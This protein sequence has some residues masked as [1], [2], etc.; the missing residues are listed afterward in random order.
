MEAYALNI[1][2]LFTG[3]SDGRHPRNPVYVIPHFQRGYTWRK[4]KILVLINDLLEAIKAES[5]Q[6]FLGAIT[7][8]SEQPLKRTRFSVIDGQQRLTTLLLIALHLLEKIPQNVKVRNRL[9]NMTGLTDE[10]IPV[11][12]TRHDDKEALE[13]IIYDHKPNG[14]GAHRINDAFSCI[15]KCLDGL[16]DRE[17]IDFAEFLLTKTKV[18]FIRASDEESCYQIFETLNNRGETLTALDLIRNRIFFA[19]SSRPELLERAHDLWSNRLTVIQSQTNKRTADAVMQHLFV[20]QIQIR[21]GNW[22]ETKELY[23]AIK[24][25]LETSQ[26][27]EAYNLLKDFISEN[28]A[29]TYIKLYKRNGALL[30]ADTQ[31]SRQ[32]SEAAEYRIFHPPL[33]ILLLRNANPEYVKKT[34]LLFRN[35]V[36]RLTLVKD[37]LPVKR[38]GTKMAKLSKI[39]KNET[40]MENGG[41]YEKVWRFIKEADAELAGVMNDETFAEAIARKPVIKTDYAKKAFIDLVNAHA[42]SEGERLKPSQTL[43]IEHILPRKPA[44]LD[45]WPAFNGKDLSFYINKFGNLTILGNKLN[46]TIS[47][48]PFARKK[49]EYLKSNYWV[50]RKISEYNTWTPETIKTRQNELISELVQVWNIQELCP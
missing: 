13:R 9:Y 42:E 7:A 33:F 25:Y 24:K 45:D 2:E 8:I 43:H 16:T 21:E 27:I 40:N 47:N 41:W 49:Q 39:L 19:I 14:T 28:A 26:G 6:Y 44:N 10:Y 38:L 36:K 50:T 23:S 11:E 48:G 22:I 32:V 34:A 29:R 5:S 35:F 12:H 20:V 1:Y 31:Y 17:L 18:V 15:E 46:Q 4:E 30:E 3:D 37:I